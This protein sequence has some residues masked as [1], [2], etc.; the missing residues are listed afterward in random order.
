VALYHDRVRQRVREANQI[1]GLLR[2]YGV[3]VRERDFARAERRPAL[4]ERL[5]AGGVLRRDLKVLWRGYDVVARQVVWLRRQ[6]VRLARREEPIGRF[7]QLPGVA[8]VRAATFFAYVDTPW[9][10]RSKSALWKYLG[11][12]LERRHSGTGPVRLQLVR[13]AHRR[14]KGVLV[15]AAKAAVRAGGNPF[16]DQYRRWREAG[17]SPRL[18]L[19][20]TARSLAAVLWGMWKN[21]SAYRPEWVGVA[22]AAAA[23]QASA[24]AGG[25]G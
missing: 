8:W 5:P 2:R 11:L 7:V 22:A 23:A 12:G 3:F 24:G 13:R 10:F 25:R 4:L 17:S 20:N 19:R 15:G 21:G 16:A 14:L 9:R 6:L 18:A 1:A